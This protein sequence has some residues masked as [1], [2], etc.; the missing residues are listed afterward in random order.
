MK[1]IIIFLIR[2]KLGLKKRQ[3]FRFTNQKSRHDYYYFT[4]DALM[5]YDSTFMVIVPSD[6]SLN[7]LLNDKCE[8]EKGE[9]LAI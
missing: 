9:M 1:R 8:I 6:V 3:R 7:W 4:N 5:K 2:K